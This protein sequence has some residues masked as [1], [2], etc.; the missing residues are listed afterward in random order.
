MCETKTSFQQY[1]FLQIKAWALACHEFRADT[2]LVFVRARLQPGRALLG[3]AEL[4]PLSPH[5]GYPV[6]TLG[7][8]PDPL[9]GIL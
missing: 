2:R 3:R 5:R 9:L 4:S 6:L 1:F 8:L 7:L